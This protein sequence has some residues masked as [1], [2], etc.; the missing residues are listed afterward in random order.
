MRGRDWRFLGTEGQGQFVGVAHRL[1]GRRYCEGDIRFYVDRGRSL[2]F[3]GTGSEDYSHQSAAPSSRRPNPSLG[4]SGSIWRTRG[5]GFGA[6]ST[7]G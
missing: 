5:R 1:I 3:Y 4:S 2:A 6:C 7:R